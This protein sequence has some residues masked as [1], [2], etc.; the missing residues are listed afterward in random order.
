MYLPTVDTLTYQIPVQYRVTS[1][2][3]KL[4][5][6]QKMSTKPITAVTNKSYAY[7]PTNSL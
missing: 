7:K 3:T 5:F 1:S 2:R 4:V 6:P